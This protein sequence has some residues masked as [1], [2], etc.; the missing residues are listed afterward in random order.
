MG[1]LLRLRASRQHLRG[2]GSCPRPRQGRRGT[3]KWPPT[4]ALPCSDLGV[5]GPHR[6]S[7]FVQGKA[8][9]RRYC[10]LTANPDVRRGG[11]SHSSAVSFCIGRSCHTDVTARLL[12]STGDSRGFGVSRSS[13][14][15]GH[16]RNSGSP[17][18]QRRLVALCPLLGSGT[19]SL[20][21]SSTRCAAD[22]VRPGFLSFASSQWSGPR[23]RPPPP[24]GR[25]SAGYSQIHGVGMC[26][27]IC[28]PAP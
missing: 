26:A 28:T 22:P 6:R 11:A 2:R 14:R 5:R 23:T 27:A 21:L 7:G 24:W 12:I 18:P 17:P 15:R 3:R 4:P 25:R 10:G 1:G 8:R 19:I 9:G 20:I 16:P 13:G